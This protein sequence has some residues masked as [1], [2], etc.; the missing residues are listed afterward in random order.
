MPRSNRTLSVSA[1]LM[2]LGLALI[3][4]YVA[5]GVHGC[6]ETEACFARMDRDYRL[7]LLGLAVFALSGAAALTA[8]VRR[9]I[10]PSG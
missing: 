2:V 1:S 8:V 3:V 7:F 9:R 5:W 4:W 10:R 6:D